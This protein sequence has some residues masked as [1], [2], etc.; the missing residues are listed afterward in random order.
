MSVYP[1]EFAPLIQT[2]NHHPFS[3]CNA[4]PPRS[5]NIPDLGLSREARGGVRSH[6]EVINSPSKRLYTH[7]WAFANSN[8]SGA[9]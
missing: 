5:E 6:L 1:G 3:V 4:A 7:S 2:S 9:F 8:D